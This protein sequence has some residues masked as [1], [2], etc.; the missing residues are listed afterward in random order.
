MQHYQSVISRG[1]SRFISRVG[2]SKRLNL[3]KG[4]DSYQ[5]ARSLLSTAKTWGSQKT[6]RS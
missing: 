5:L 3:G 2:L 1:E 6:W 4:M